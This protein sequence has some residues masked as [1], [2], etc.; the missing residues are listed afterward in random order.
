M[1]DNGTNVRLGVITSVAAMP[2]VSVVRSRGGTR[3]SVKVDPARW[4]GA[5]PGLGCLTEVPAGT[6]GMLT[7]VKVRPRVSV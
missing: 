1:R 7:L 4:Y 3:T 5:L 2:L 6:G